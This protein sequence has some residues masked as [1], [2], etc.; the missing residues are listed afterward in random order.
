MFS[1]LIDQVEIVDFG[2]FFLLS[3][4]SLYCCKTAKNICTYTVKFDYHKYYSYV[5]VT[6]DNLND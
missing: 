6:R 2:L 5:H 1:T 3:E 4:F